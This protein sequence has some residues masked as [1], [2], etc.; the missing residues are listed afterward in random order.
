MRISHVQ[1]THGPITM[2]IKKNIY[3][4]KKNREKISDF[5][6]IQNEWNEQYTKQQ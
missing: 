1:H 2:H 4:R 6:Q 5:S 3:E